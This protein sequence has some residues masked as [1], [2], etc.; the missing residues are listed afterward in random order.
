M[1]CEKKIRCL[2]GTD[3]VRDVA[4]KGLMTPELALRLG[5]SYV[6]Y[7]TER[8]APR[9]R[10]V[11]GRD[12]RRSG[13]MIE[14]AVIAGMM[15]AGA[16]VLTAGVIPTPG[17]SFLVR[18]H[19]A[20]GGCIISAS[21]NPA[22]YNGIKF[23]D[24]DG[25]KLA[26]DSEASIE[27]YLGDNLID[28]WR[29]TGASIGVSED[30]SSG[31]TDYARW[32]MTLL[33]DRDLPEKAVVVDCANGAAVSVFSKISGSLP[34]WSF[35]GMRPDGLNINDGFGVM[36]MAALSGEVLAKNASFGIAYDGDADRVLCVDGKG[37]MIDGDIML[38]VLGRWMSRRGT[39]GSGVVATVM[40]NMALEEHLSSEGIR[41]FRCPVGDRYVM[42]TMRQKTASLGGEQSG[43]IILSE[44]VKTGD[45]LCT[46]FLFLRACMELEE[47]IST[48]ADRFGRYPQLLR[49]VEISGGSKIGAEELREL[50]ETASEML[51]EEGRVLIRPSGTEPLLRVLVEAKD[52]ARMQEVSDT[53]LE[54]IRTTSLRSP[55]ATRQGGF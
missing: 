36:H 24:G 46:G 18:H 44:Y 27:E 5:R 30:V 41:V 54:R 53:I 38:W 1:E 33:H 26:D 9:P 10:V 12:T 55:T 25:C 45:G 4:N 6:L 14:A 22:E 21:H 39:L 48:L 51:G 43:H 11:V 28:D 29:P 7:L 34:G 15:S 49:N 8:G 42:E 16:H 31:G 2:F 35:I 37:R 32:I 3:G 23:L 40:S 52:P 20:N 47:D 19:S 17:V 50:S 13:V